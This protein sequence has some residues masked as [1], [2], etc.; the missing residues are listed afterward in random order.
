MR[1]R[2]SDVLCIFAML[3]SFFGFVLCV[4]VAGYCALFISS[5]F[6]F[7]GVAVFGIGAWLFWLLLGDT[8]RIGS[9]D[10]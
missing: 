7:Y 10:K 8:A 3:A 5:G 9:R 2:T 4:G 6:P 1:I